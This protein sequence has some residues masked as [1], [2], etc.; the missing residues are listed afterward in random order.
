MIA[1]AD[2]IHLLP[3]VATGLVGL[4]ALLFARRQDRAAKIKI[5]RIEHQIHEAEAR[6]LMSL[7]EKNHLSR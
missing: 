6:K 7:I 5:E 4:V 2:I 3:I 1:L